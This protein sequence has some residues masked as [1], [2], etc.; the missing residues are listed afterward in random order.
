MEFN[1]DSKTIQLCI[2]GM[3]LEGQGRPSA[4]MLLFQEAWDVAADGIEKFTAAHYLARH[5]GSV[6]DKL[7]WDEIALQ[8]ALNINGDTVK[9]TYPSLYLNVAKCYEDLQDPQ[10]AIKHYELAASFIHF[11]PDDGYGNMIRAGILHG[12]ERVKPLK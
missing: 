10:N 4:A 6:A 1:Q 7:K 8:L 11:L 9:S 2:Q 3:E 12:I 5:Q